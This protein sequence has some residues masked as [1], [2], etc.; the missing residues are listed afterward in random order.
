M[1]IRGVK[2]NRL[3]SNL[4]EK[5]SSQVDFFLTPKDKIS[6]NKN[7]QKLR[8]SQSIFQLTTI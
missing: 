2:E 7:K 6:D 1:T 3:A 8:Q 5:N 4:L